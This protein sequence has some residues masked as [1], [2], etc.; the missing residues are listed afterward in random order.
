MCVCV[1]VSVSVCT[2]L[3]KNFN[4]V[5]L[6]NVMVFKHSKSFLKYI[7]TFTLSTYYSVVGFIHTKH[8]FIE[9]IKRY[10]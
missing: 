10:I 8:D 2:M 4:V 3:S 5:F 6:D 7:L 9:K 1:C